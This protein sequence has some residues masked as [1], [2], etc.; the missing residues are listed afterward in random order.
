MARCHRLIGK[1]F[2]EDP[3]ANLDRAEAA[4]ERA[5]EIDPDLSVAHKVYAHL[6]A[7]GGRAREAMVRLLGLARR[8]RND[9]EVFAALVHSCRYAGLLGPSL[10]AHREVRRLDPLISTSVS[11]THWMR[12]DFQAVLAETGDR[13]D[14]ELPLFALRALGH[15][16]EERRLV[17][18]VRADSSSQAHQRIHEI[19]EAFV[20]DDLD[21][22]RQVFRRTAETHT[23]PE[24]LF[25]Y[26][27]ALAH[28]GDVDG[29]V[30]TLTRAV[31]GGFL[32][33]DA[34]H[35]PWLAGLLE[36]DD[37][38]ALM[39][40]AESEKAET[41]RAFRDSGGPELLGL[42]S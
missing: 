30:T 13:D 14:H 20:S 41:E 24:A 18:R 12:G 21:R 34:W 4:L 5:L 16:D 11:Y 7:E 28:V 39:A 29:A 23:D 25:I 27:T 38:A 17:E 40:K 6:E 10:A 26:G 31:R 37:V 42:P 15:R 3:S 33:P 2:L 36:R 19:A 1:Y 32:V 22:A 8:R 9:P 35:H